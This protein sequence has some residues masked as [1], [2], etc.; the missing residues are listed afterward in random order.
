MKERK[1]IVAL[2]ILRECEKCSEAVKSKK[3]HHLMC[4]WDGESSI[5]CIKVPKCGCWPEW[6]NQM[7]KE[8]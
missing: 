8:T 5:P 7:L 4:K 3:N 2:F 6:L 1:A